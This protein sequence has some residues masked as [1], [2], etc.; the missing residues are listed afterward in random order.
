MHSADTVSNDVVAI[1]H[2]A[3]NYTGW[4]DT[5]L[6]GEIASIARFCFTNTGGGSNF[7]IAVEALSQ[8]TECDISVHVAIYDDAGAFTL[9]D[10]ASPRVDFLKSAQNI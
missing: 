4:L 7:G 3:I 6:A 10:T 9:P 2:M 5:P 8:S 1:Y